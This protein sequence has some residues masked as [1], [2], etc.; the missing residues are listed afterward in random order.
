MALAFQGCAHVDVERQLDEKLAKEPAVT[1]RARLLSES[2]R[3]IATAPGLS[4]DQRARLIKLRDSTQVVSDRL[5]Q[6]LF[7]EEGLLLR[8]VLDADTDPAEID[9]LKKRIRDTEQERLALFFDTVRNANTI[10]GRWPSR[11]ERQ[12]ED[13]FDQMMFEMMDVNYPH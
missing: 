11:S 8:K 10:L 7:K 3:L 2:G 6:K 9:L 1:E 4:N 12:N 13:F 5:R